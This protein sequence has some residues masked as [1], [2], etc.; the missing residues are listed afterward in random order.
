MFRGGGCGLLR[1]VA[2]VPCGRLFTCGAWKWWVGL[3]P[4][5]GVMASA[6]GLGGGGFRLW[7]TVLPV[8]CGLWVAGCSW[9]GSG[10]LVAL[11]PLLVLVVQGVGPG[12]EHACGVWRP[13]CWSCWEASCSAVS[14]VAPCWP[15]VG[16]LAVVRGVV[17]GCC[18]SH[19]ALFGYPMGV[20]GCPV[21]CCDVMCVLVCCVWCRSV[22]FL[23]CLLALHSLMLF[24]GACSVWCV[25]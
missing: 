10:R 16:V 17:F 25:L 24:V 3:V 5:G 19:P 2:L 22:V 14:V 13:G 12:G 1:A 15:L 23:A 8:G 18:S 6:A 20:V 4:L 7:W 9:C 21:S 11:A